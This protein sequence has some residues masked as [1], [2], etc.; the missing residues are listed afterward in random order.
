MTA[1][2]GFQFAPEVV[3]YGAENELLADTE[4][5]ATAGMG[6]PGGVVSLRIADWIDEEEHSLQS[7][8]R[9][10]LFLKPARSRRAEPDRTSDPASL[11][12]RLLGV[13]VRP[14]TSPDLNRYRL[15]VRG[16]VVI[17]FTYHHGPLADVGFEADDMIMEVEGRPIG[18]LQ[19]FAEQL[20]RLR[21]KHRI[22]MLG[23]DHRTGRP[24]YVQV[25][26]PK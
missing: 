10:L 13:D 11:I 24:G 23:L 20:L 1:W 12:R 15:V 2:I 4:R 3:A 21:G 9:E 16:A 17:M 19:E 22:L 26:V 14:A 7:K 8:E 25:V 18:G 5:L 6:I